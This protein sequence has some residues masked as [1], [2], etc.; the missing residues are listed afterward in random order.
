[1][2]GD[3][4]RDACKS[5]RFLQLFLSADFVFLPLLLFALETSPSIPLHPHHAGAD[6]GITSSSHQDALSPRLLG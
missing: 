5:G 4:S 1:M 2:E 3:V 6:R